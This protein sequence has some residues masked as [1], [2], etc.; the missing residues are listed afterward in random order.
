MTCEL[1]VHNKHGKVFVFLHGQLLYTGSWIGYDTSTR[2]IPEQNQ[3]D[4]SLAIREA[5]HVYA[6]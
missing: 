2:S 1:N 5:D 6:L 4:R 3:D